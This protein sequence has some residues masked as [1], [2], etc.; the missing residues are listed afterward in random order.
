MREII[1]RS[2]SVLTLFVVLALAYIFAVRHNPTPAPR[3]PTP[4]GTAAAPVAAVLPAP[5]EIHVRA[6]ELFTVHGCATCH[7]VGGQGNPR[8]PLDDVGNQCTPEDILAWTTG[9]GEAAAQL[10]DNLRRRKQRYI[11]LPAP[12]LDALVAWLATQREPAR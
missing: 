1:A 8:L 7:S 12:D 4:T 2:L 10:S 6:R 3:G 9:T 11:D 5:P